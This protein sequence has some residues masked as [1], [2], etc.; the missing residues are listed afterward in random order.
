MNKKEKK[1]GFFT[2]L[3]EWWQN[4]RYKSLIILGIYVVLFGLIERI[5]VEYSIT[6]PNKTT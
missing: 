3:H 5:I 1:V 2:K 4:P 6:S